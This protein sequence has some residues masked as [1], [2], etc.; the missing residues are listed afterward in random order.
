[1]NKQL[2]L[3]CAILSGIIIALIATLLPT[4]QMNHSS[5]T[6]LGLISSV[7]VYILLTPVI[8]SRIKHLCCDLDWAEE[9][10][11]AYHKISPIY[12]KSFWILFGLINLAYLFHTINFI[13]GGEDWSA[14]RTTVDINESLTQ[15]RFS[16]FILQ[17]LLFNGKILPVANNLW[18]FFG[19]SLSAI[20]LAKYWNLSK[21]TSII[22]ISGL[23]LSVNPYTMSW[24]YS[25]K[26]TLGIMWLP[27]IS[28]TAL[29]LSENSSESTTR[30]SAKNIVSVIM[31]LMVLGTY[32]PVLAF[33]GV[34][35]LGKVFLQTVYAGA[36]YKESFLKT[37]QSLTN[38]T[39]ALMI[40]I[41]IE[42]IL[43]ETNTLHLSNNLMAWSALIWSNI[44]DYLTATISQ[45]ITPL[46]FT[47]LGYQLLSLLLPLI[48]IFCI[49]Y[50]SPNTKKALQGIG[51]FI[52]I[53]L[54]SKLPILF[55]IH[56]E[57]LADNL[58]QT[59]FFSLPLIYTLSFITLIS[60][61]KK[62]LY[63]IGYTLAVLIIFMGFVRVSY[64]QKVWKF[65]WDAETKLAERI[66][67]RLE[68]LPEFNIERQYKLIQIGEM[69]LRS[70]YYIKKPHE[71]ANNNLLNGAYYPEGNSKDAYNFFYQA[72]FL[73][74]NASTE[75]LKLPAIRE[76]LLNTARAWP[77]EES[78]WIYD[79]YIIMVIDEQALALTQ[80]YLTQN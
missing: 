35:V 71:I 57:S 26:N 34:A 11:Q 54:V 36:S 9:L 39:S 58:A 50:Q 8:A 69:S 22:V 33:I 2:N 61:S 49:I 79:D 77:A 80:R 46:P 6:A 75:A 17:Y 70:K 15:G 20:L 14:V 42:L 31:N 72:D 45:F 59:N 60:L 56:K 67:T 52:G 78:L 68:Q 18:A 62:Y 5:A 47:D 44:P 1:M 41:F 25:A 28:L 37:C 7:F 66:I 65:G 74:E 76:Y 32:F 43:I 40:Y 19:L 16:A 51:L 13:W 30:N 24:L 64:A 10:N 27:A 73:S 3:L 29:L 12:R 53:I 21:Q 63:R 48:T 4:V 23:L 38:L 55:N